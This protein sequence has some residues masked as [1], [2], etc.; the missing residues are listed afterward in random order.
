PPHEQLQDGQGMTRRVD[1]APAQVGNQQLLSAKDVQWQKAPVAVVPMEVTAF[2]IP[3]YP[4]IG[5]IEVQDQLRECLFERRDELLEHDLVEATA[6]LRLARCSSLQR[7]ESLA[8]SSVR[9]RA[10]CHARSRRR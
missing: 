1:V 5:G 3:V 4:V 2:L 7:A 9:S 6:A 10:V 8:K